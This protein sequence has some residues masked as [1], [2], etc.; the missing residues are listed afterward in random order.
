MT[1]E[2]AVV[3]WKGETIT[4][5]FQDVKNL[6][7]PLAT[8]Q[9]TAVFLKTCQS[10][11]LNPFAGEVYLIKYSDKDKAAIVIGIDAYL[12][13]AEANPNFD[14]YEGGIILKDSTGNLEYREGAFLLDEEGQKLVGGWA[15]VYRKDRSRPFYMAVN[16]KECI[17]YRRDGTPTEFWT[18]EKQ[19]SML[20]KVALKRALVEA[21]PSLFSGLISNVDYE[22][23]PDEPK[24]NTHEPELPPV[25][26]KNGQ[27]DWA[28]FW[29]RVNSE[30]GLTAE[31]ARSLLGVNSIKEEL[32]NNG[33]TMEKIWD[34]LIRRL[35]EKKLKNRDPESIRSL[36]DL[37]RACFEDFKM[38][39]KDVLKEL[40]YKTQSDIAETPA[41]C[42]RRIA[43]IKT[44]N[45]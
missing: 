23:S 34:E 13:A 44:L 30:L 27:P 8:D 19:P 25:L 40:G 29:A 42:Y 10:L 17:R 9:E 5:S 16:K 35:Q 20:R 1:T 12:K 7:C 14:G 43:A 2:Q 22:V 6:I 31:A 26:E 3:Q 39:P 45:V 15:K 38:Q 24:G 28:K 21:F 11:Q 18:E 32:I 41:E 37:M 33:W 4:I 36:N